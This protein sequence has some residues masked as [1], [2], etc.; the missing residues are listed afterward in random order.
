MLVDR[1]VA[2]AIQAR[3]RTAL[4]KALAWGLQGDVQPLGQASY[5]VPSRT[6]PGLLYTVAVTRRRG[7]EHLA[8]SCPAGVADLPC[9]HS[10]A[11][12]LHRLEQRSG[13]TVIGVHPV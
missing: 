11:V 4:A 12:Y 10:A 2:G 5:R 9:V 8:C 7:A 13:V 3:R 6:E 1:V